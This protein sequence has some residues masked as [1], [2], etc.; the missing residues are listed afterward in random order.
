MTAMKAMEVITRAVD[1]IAGRAKAMFRRKGKT[2][3]VHQT[4]H[5]VDM[6]YDMFSGTYK[7]N[8]F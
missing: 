2:I 5:G 6:Y 3:Q 1:S 4:V 7:Q 8:T